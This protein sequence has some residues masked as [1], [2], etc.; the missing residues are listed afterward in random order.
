MFATEPAGAKSMRDGVAPEP[1][2]EQLLVNDQA[3]LGVRHSRDLQIALPIDRHEH[4]VGN[5]AVRMGCAAGYWA[6]PSP[7]GLRAGQLG[8]SRRLIWS[9]AADSA[10]RTRGRGASRRE[11]AQRCHAPTRIC[12]TASPSPR[13]SHPA[14]RVATMII[15]E[16][17]AWAHLPKAGGDATHAMLASVPGLV[18]FADPPDSNDKHLPFF[19]REAEIAGKLLVMN[20]R[21][22]PAWTLS[23]AHH[24]A[25]HGVHPDYRPLPLESEDEMTGKTDADDLLRWMTDHGRFAV[26]RWLRTESL[27]Q[28]VLALLGELGVSSGRVR[29]RIRAVGRV[30]EGAY[31]R[32]ELVHFSEDQLRRLYELNPIWA[33]IERR[34]YGGL[35]YESARVSRERPD[36]HR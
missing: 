31:D 32:H 4:P 22:L 28:D 10:P 18:R 23:G 29:R 20:I 12:Y 7:L 36:L 24:K 16:R 21:R 13:Q 15:G 5:S 8:G 11:L 30:N 26:D 34:A 14:D 2:G 25:A 17:F 19:A 1:R 9:I 6:H 35:P 33:G 27:E 3:F